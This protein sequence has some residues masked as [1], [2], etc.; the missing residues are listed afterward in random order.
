VLSNAFPLT[1]L[2]S[3]PPLSIN[4]KTYFHQFVGVSCNLTKAGAHL[5]R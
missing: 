1:L 2:A 3:K 5:W 4:D